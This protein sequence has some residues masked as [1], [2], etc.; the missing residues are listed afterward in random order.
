MYSSG[1]LSLLDFILSIL[2]FSEKAQWALL[3][4]GGPLR[5]ARSPLNLSL[6]II[7]NCKSVS[8][9]FSSWGISIFPNKIIDC[10]KIFLFLPS[11]LLIIDKNLL[12]ENHFGILKVQVVKI[13]CIFQK[14]K[15]TK[16][17]KN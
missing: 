3:E 16:R 11:I 15:I 7:T 8:H 14:A 2:G 5:G 12:C 9:K 10:L 17:W 6:I 4:S 1:W 13:K